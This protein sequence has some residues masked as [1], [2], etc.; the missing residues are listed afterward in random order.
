M[1]DVDLAKRLLYAGAATVHEAQDRRGSIGASVRPV[2]T[3]AA[4]AGPCRT[5]ELPGGDN[6]AVHIALEEA[7]PGEILVVAGRTAAPF[8][9]WGAILTEYALAQGVAGLVTNLAVRDVDAIERLRFPVFAAYVCLQGT[10]KADPGFHQVPVAVGDGV[11]LPA[12]WIVAD[13]DGCVVVSAATVEQVAAAAEL[14]VAREADIIEAIRG[15]SSSRDALGL[16]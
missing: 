5:V 2:W 12:D 15:G 6:L 7:Q 10:T 14:K 1:T 16:S 4:A 3:G 13:S 11:V 8:G 9:F